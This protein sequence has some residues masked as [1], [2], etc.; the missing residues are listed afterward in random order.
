MPQSAVEW[1]DLCGEGL[2][3]VVL[4]VWDKILVGLQPVRAIAHRQQ[5]LDLLLKDLTCFD[6]PSSTGRAEDLAKDGVHR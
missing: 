3:R 1:F 6:R 4:G 5:V 2:S